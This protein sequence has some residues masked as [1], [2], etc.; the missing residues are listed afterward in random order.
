[1][2]AV[3]LFDLATTPGVSGVNECVNSA[4]QISVTG[5]TVAIA[6]NPAGADA[7]NATN[8]WLVTHNP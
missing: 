3:T 4:G 1:M 6:F 2:G 7:V 5:Q 8:T